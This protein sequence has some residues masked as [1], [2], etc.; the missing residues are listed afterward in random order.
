MNVTRVCFVG[1][2]TAAFDETV[3][4]FRD[5]LGLEPAFANPKWA[6]FKLGSGPRDFVEVFG[7]RQHDERLFPSEVESGCL[8]AFAVDD[9]VTA[10]A[11][12]SAAGVELINEIV[13]ADDVFND[14]AYAGFGW[15]FFR[16]PDDN[17]YVLQQERAPEPA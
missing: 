12:L 9:V 8:V 15:C 4:C 14:S 10:R 3:A 11:E 6:G 7:D 13:W 16:A 17:I 2:R 1:T 5:V